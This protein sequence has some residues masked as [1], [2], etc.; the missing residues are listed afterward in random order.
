MKKKIISLALVVV[1]TMLCVV[2]LSACKDGDKDDINTIVIWAG[3]QW[4]GTDLQNLK[5]FVREYNESNELGVTVEVVAKSDMETTLVTAVKNNK[6]PDI[7]I[8]D[9]FNTPTTAE[10]GA[11]LDITEYIKRDNI[12]TTLFNDDAMGELMYDGK[13]YGLPLDLDVWGTYVNMDLVDKYNAAHPDDKIVLNDNWTWDDLY[14]T[15]QKLTVVENGTMKVAGYTGHVMHQHFFKYLCSTSQAFLTPE[16]V[17]N[18]NTQQARDVLKF[19]KKVGGKD[20]GIWTGGI[21]EKDNFRAGQVAIIDQSLY[22]TDYI[23]RYSKTLNYKF[24]PQPRYSVNGVVQE[25]AVNGGMLGGFGLAFPKPVDRYINDDFYAKFEKAW[26][27]AQ[28][29]L[30]NEDM[31]IKWSEKTGTLPALKS[32]YTSDTVLENETL[33]RAASFV[34][35]YSVRPQ[36]PGYFTI[37]TQVFD[38][39]I[40]AYVESDQDTLET[41]INSLVEG[42]Q[43][44]MS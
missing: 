7:L 27:F 11:L 16:G 43:S 4:T 9:R 38:N 15:A 35:D 19:F 8:W 10:K 18:F 44:Y 13:C 28:D 42:C 3:G 21:V 5:E 2:C 24:M 12:D 29:W 23:E 26:S 32:L 30:L 40:K 25:G 17:P 14:T 36:I 37:Q 34:D 6:V 1:L 39:Y 22:F 20:N 33:R 41:T 31:Q